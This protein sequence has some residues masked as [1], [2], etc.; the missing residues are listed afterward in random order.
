VTWPDF[1]RIN[2]PG[3]Q[4]DNDRRKALKDALKPKR[5]YDVTFQYKDDNG[6]LRCEKI[7]TN[8]V[9]RVVACVPRRGDGG[10][11]DRSSKES[12]QDKIHVTQ[13]VS[14]DS[15]QERTDF[16]TKLGLPADS[17]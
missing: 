8:T 17:R 2:P 10:S 11:D 16:L 3:A 14:F 4:D 12:Y 15:Y 1:V 13:S 7:N 6:K 9:G 5:K